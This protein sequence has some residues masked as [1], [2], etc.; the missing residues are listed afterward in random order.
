MG[1]GGGLLK[2]GKDFT[3]DKS[4]S[5]LEACFLDQPL[6]AKALWIHRHMK[7]ERVVQE[8]NA[9]TERVRLGA[10]DVVVMNGSIHAE[11]SINLQT[12][13]NL[14]DCLK[15]KQNGKRNVRF[16]SFVYMHTGAV[17]HFPTSNGEFDPS[18]LE[19]DEPGLCRQE[20]T[21]RDMFVEESLVLGG[22]VP[23]VGQEVVELQFHAGNLHV[24]GKDCL[25]W[26]QPGIPDLLAVNVSTFVASL[27]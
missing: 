2:L 8:H 21:R 27:V 22:K 9:T 12:I 25:H 6:F 19:Q 10:R 15:A 5:W 16:P 3:V 13:G 17:D 14:I 1:P 24:G 20:A 23:L 26:V 4:D 7:G 18:F 11:R